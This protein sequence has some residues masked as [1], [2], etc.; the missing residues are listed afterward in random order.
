MDLVARKAGWR[1]KQFIEMLLKKAEI[2][3]KNSETTKVRF[4]IVSVEE[5]ILYSYF[6]EISNK[7]LVY[8]FIT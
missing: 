1:E 6:C 2:L 7:L 4:W 5:L 8:L 3:C